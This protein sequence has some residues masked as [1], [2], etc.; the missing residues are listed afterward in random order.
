MLYRESSAF[1][2]FGLEVLTPRSC[3]TV[4]VTAQLKNKVAFIRAIHSNP[5]NTDSQFMMF[6]YLCLLDFP[7]TSICI[8]LF[9]VF[10]Q[11]GTT[12]H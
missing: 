11:V 7:Y 2:S 10:Y 5:V 8:G 6:S 12:D 4:V 1:H 3:H 9:I